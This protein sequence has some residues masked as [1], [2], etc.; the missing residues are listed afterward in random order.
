[1]RKALEC[2][3]VALVSAL[4]SAIF[5]YRMSIG[6]LRYIQRRQQSD[7]AKRKQKHSAFTPPTPPPEATFAS[8]HVSP[9][10][11]GPK[12]HFVT[13]KNMFASF[14]RSGTSKGVFIAQGRLPNM[15]YPMGLMHKDNRYNVRLEDRSEQLARILQPILGSPDPNGRQLNGLG[16]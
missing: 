13:T 4:R 12:N 16:E 15:V 11:L 1:M 14:W 5:G 6:N 7:R 10:D 3:G 9:G 8:S 2:P